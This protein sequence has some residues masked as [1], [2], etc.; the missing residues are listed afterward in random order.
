MLVR[1]SQ[2]DST[3]TSQKHDII[4]LGSGL[5]GLRAAIEAARNPDLDIAIVSKVQLMR[6]HSVCAEGGTAAVM[7]PDEGDSF[8]LHSWDTVRGADFLCDQDVV[9]RF[10]EASPKE[11][12]LLEH[13]GIPWSRRPDGRIAQRP[14]GGH[15]YDRTVFAADKTGFA[16]MQ[17]LYDTLQKYSNVSRYDECYVSSILTKDNK[18]CGVTAWDLTSGEFFLI[19]GKALI[20]ATGGACRMFGFTTYSLTAT[21]DGLAMAYRAGLP[22]KDLEFVQFHPTGLVPSGILI[23]EAA[24]GEGGYL[25]NN[26]DERFMEKYAPSKMEVAPRDI[27]SR[28]EMTEIEEGRGFPG[29]DGLDY[30]HIDL[31]HLGAAKINERL[32]MI[33]EV[34]MKFNFIDP[35][36]KPIPIRPAAHYFM[37]GV[38]TDINGATPIEGIWAAGEAACVSLHGAN[39]LGSNSTTECLVWGKITGEEAA[40]YASKHKALPSPQKA[41]T[42]KEEEARVFSRF[43][44]DGKESAYVLRRELQRTMDSKV[45]VFRT[46]PDLKSALNKIQEIKNSLPA[47]KVK[48]RGRIYNTDLL[49][50]LEADNL[51]DLAEIIVT[52]ALARTESRGAHSRRDFPNRDDVNWLKHTLAHYT[53][54]G[55]RLDYIP[56]TITMWQPVERKY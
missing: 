40:K 17:A 23:T 9:K 2:G 22:I 42:L 1:P 4:V 19:Q 28:S 31:R 7:Q 14:F 47:I 54:K 38:H 25:L 30:V 52:G 15:S 16:E 8:E 3:V 45:G 20:I 24:R 36:Y 11:I 10:V 13:W 50:A 41:T 44:S 32:P 5:A 18:F 6:S 12:L 48:D 35:I 43:S 37:G 26:E 39:R 49:S 51:V 21:G 33:R 29:P 34:A 56:V 46:G 27:V 55:P 53:P